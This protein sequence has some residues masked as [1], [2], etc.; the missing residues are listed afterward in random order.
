M[1]LPPPV[2]MPPIDLLLVTLHQC[3]E[4]ESIATASA[5][6]AGWWRERTKRLGDRENY[7]PA[8][9]D[10]S[11]DMGLDDRMVCPAC[12]HVHADDDTSWV[13]EFEGQAHYREGDVG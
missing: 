2:S 8:D 13:S 6:Q 12:G 5:W 4:C 10:R 1:T 9:F 3:S 11:G 7:P